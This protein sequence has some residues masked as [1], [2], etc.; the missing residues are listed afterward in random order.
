[1]SLL[2]AIESEYD[3][4][5]DANASINRGNLPYFF[6]I[7]LGNILYIIGLFICKIIKLV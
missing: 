1:M 2:Q 6:I 7:C 5:E 3:E 4:E